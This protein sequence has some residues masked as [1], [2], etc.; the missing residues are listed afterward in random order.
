MEIMKSIANISPGTGDQFRPWMAAVV[1]IV[2]VVVLVSLIISNRKEN[3]EERNDY[4]DED[5]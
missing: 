1:L 4:K 5:E 2:S 3:Q